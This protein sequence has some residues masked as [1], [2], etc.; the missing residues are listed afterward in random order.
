MISQKMIERGTFE[1]NKPGVLK[2][3]SNRMQMLTFYDVK[4]QAD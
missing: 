4:V 2:I 3:F 1:L